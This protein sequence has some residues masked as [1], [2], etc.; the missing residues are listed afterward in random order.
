MWPAP[1]QDPQ[2]FIDIVRDIEGACWIALAPSKYQTGDVAKLF[3]IHVVG[4]E[5]GCKFATWC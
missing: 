4:C 2:Y 3:A 1:S 5:E